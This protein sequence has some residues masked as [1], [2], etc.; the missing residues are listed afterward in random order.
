[1]GSK[2]VILWSVPVHIEKAGLISGGCIWSSIS[3]RGEGGLFYRSV[4]ASATQECLSHCN[5]VVS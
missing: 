5:S 2:R 4:S 3:A 1:M